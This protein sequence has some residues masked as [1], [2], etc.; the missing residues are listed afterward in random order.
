MSHG[1]GEEQGNSGRGD[2]MNKR[3]NAMIFY[4]GKGKE[5]E[6]K[7]H[8]EDKDKV[9]EFGHKRQEMCRFIFKGK[10]GTDGECRHFR[11]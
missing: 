11:Q 8:Q 5:T 3:G 6:G 1:L 2:G 4:R 9:T 7:S 10:E